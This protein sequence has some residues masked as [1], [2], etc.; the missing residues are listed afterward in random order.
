MAGVPKFGS[1]TA[2]SANWSVPL[3]PRQREGPR[4]AIRADGQIVGWLVS[5]PVERLT[6][7]ADIT[8][9]TQQR[10]T[11]WLIVALAALLAAAVAWFTARGLLAPVK[12][13]I[14]ATHQLAAG[15]FSARVPE[16][17]RDELGRPGARF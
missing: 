14:M 13:L 17:S 16:S 12:R 8:F 3:A 4:Y 9:D 11:S 15:D 6:R 1:W 10:R 2:A 5:T 7:N